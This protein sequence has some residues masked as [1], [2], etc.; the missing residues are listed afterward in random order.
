M[1]RKRLREHEYYYRDVVIGSRIDALAYAFLN[2]YTLVFN[3]VQPP[4]FFEKLGDVPKIK[5]WNM[6]CF[7]MSFA[8]DMAISDKVVSVQV[9]EK[10]LLV[11]TKVN[12]LV[13][14]NFDRL[15]V[16]DDQHVYG[17]G[18][19]KHDFASKKTKV[20]DWM[21]SKSMMGHDMEEIKTGDDFV[22]A[23]HFFKVNGKNKEM[24]VISQ[25]LHK[26]LKEIE[27]SDTYAM[28]KTLK[29]LK[30]HQIKG[31][32][33]GRDS[34]DPSKKKHYALKIS[35]YKREV[36]FPFERMYE[37]TN[38]VMFPVEEEDS[39]LTEV[40]EEITLYV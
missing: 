9:E 14:I 10:R 31:N 39:L 7:E 8:G 3:Q 34:S 4:L 11:S 2:G 1:N 33:N 6:L 18:T 19:P 40:L 15:H 38:S 36:R 17:L 24:A 21:N 13:K 28:F 12:R 26:K 27:Y 35:P 30:D 25:M 32:D 20:I 37:N 16:F 22:Q 29:H 23:I 5:I